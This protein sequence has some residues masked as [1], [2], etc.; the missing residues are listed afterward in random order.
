MGRYPVARIDEKYLL[1]SWFG[2]D[3]AF[4][5]HQEKFLKRD[6]PL[7]HVLRSA[8]GDAE[9]ARRIDHGFLLLD[10]RG[11]Y[12]YGWFHETL[13]K[14]RWYEEYCQETGDSPVLIVNSP[15]RDFQR[16]S[17]RWMGYEPDD[18]IEHDSDVSR[19]GELAVAPHP[20]RLEGNP[21]SGFASELRWVGERIVS[22]LPD[23]DRTFSN[24]VYVSRAD[25]DRRRVRNERAVLDVL[26]PRGFESYEPGR[27]SLAE[28][29]RLFASADVVVGLHGLAYVNLMFCDGNTRLLELFAEDGTDESYFVL[30][31]EFDMT[32]ECM[33]CESI[34]DGQNK[35]AIN[36][37]VIVDTARLEAIVDSLIEEQV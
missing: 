30:A 15:L 4:F 23:G 20:I 11:S 36:R 34:H 9:P 1:P 33:V 6:V 21:S 31:N 24:R 22:N 12:R 2:V 27:L 19:V 29:A 3:T 13:P 14:L 17:L 26:E 16:R 10:E 18:W 25:A 28:Q 32:Y 5:L 35:R 7:G 8:V 37:D